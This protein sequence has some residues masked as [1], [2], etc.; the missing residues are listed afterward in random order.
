MTVKVS[1]ELLFQIIIKTTFCNSHI[2]KKTVS[3]KNIIFINLSRA[4][5]VIDINKEKESE[6][7]RERYVNEKKEREREIGIFHVKF[8]NLTK[9]Q[10]QKCKVKITWR[11]GAGVKFTV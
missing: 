8:Q 2:Q 4:E 10:F 5:F 1:K 9:R 3:A 11:M 7:K 6:R